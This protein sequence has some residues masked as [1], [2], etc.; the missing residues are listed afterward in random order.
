MLLILVHVYI[1]FR[2]CY[3]ISK[4]LFYNINKERTGFLYNFN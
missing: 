4:P 2:I 1:I 3:N